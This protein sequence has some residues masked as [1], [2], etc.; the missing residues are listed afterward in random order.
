[1]WDLKTIKKMNKVG[2]VTTND[3]KTLPLE[4]EIQKQILKWLRRIGFS[5][6]VITSGLY[7]R[8]G[9]SD[10][11]GS[12]NTGKF[13]AVEVKRGANKASKLQE[14]WLEEKRK[15]G[16]YAYVANSV[17]SLKEQ[18]KKDILEDM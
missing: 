1:M 17:D 8:S 2:I 12:T 18:M 14:E 7:N 16:A 9:I 3:T 4:K 10:I 13:I 5:V 6:D 11:V 15:C